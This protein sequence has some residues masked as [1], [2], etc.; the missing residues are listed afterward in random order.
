MSLNTRANFLMVVSIIFAIYSL[1]WGLA[2]FSEFNI[3]A[4][5]IL[6][7]A[8][9]PIDNLEI[10]LDRNTMWLSAIGAGL[11]AAVSVFLG[12]LVVPAIRERNIRIINTTILAMSLWYVIDSAGS[13]AAG[14]ISNVFFNSIYLVLVLIP[15]VCIGKNEAT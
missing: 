13:I 10:P 8:D 12:G 3:S 15:L 1:L 9:W 2:P 7:L 4:R 6:D 5:F 14:V 11:L